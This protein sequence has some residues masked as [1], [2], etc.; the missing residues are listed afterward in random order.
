LYV[1]RGGKGLIPL[2]ECDGTWEEVAVAALDQL[3][4]NGRFSKLAV[5]RYPEPL[6]PLLRASSF[7]PTPK[8]LVRYA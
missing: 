8:G 3:L 1:E 6:E 5:Q 7:V 4:G 2:R